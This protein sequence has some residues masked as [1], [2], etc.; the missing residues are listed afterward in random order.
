M[1]WLDWDPQLL[2][3][4]PKTP[5]RSIRGVPRVRQS[6]TDFQRAWQRLT[7]WHESKAGA[8]SEADRSSGR[9]YRRHLDLR[10]H[11]R[12]I[13]LAYGRTDV[14]PAIRIAAQLEELGFE[15]F[16]DQ[17]IGVGNRWALSIAEELRDAAAIIVLV[18]RHARES[19]WI[20][21]EVEY[22]RASKTPIDLS[23][24]A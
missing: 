21:H 14:E 8:S 12:K 18:S 23:D 20:A 16:T 15:T 11:R 1:T 9:P 13:F 3:E 7:E 5:G 2:G 24:L 22:A 4:A 6:E 17:D 19:R 10:Y